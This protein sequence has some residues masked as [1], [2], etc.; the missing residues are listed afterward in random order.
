MSTGNAQ[1]NR[2]MGVQALK[3]RKATVLL[4]NVLYF[5]NVLYI[6]KAPSGYIQD[7]TWTDPQK[8]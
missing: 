8:P 7:P 4:H 3:C 5:N 2:R 6:S 1:A